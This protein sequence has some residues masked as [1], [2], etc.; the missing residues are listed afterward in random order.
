MNRLA[1]PIDQEDAAGKPGLFKTDSFVLE[2]R[3]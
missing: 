1:G 2:G 3:L